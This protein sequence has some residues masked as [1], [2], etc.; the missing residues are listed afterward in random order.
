MET[1]VPLQT[2]QLL[3]RPQRSCRKT[4]PGQEHRPRLQSYSVQAFGG[5]AGLAI[6]LY[7]WGG[8]G[9]EKD[10]GL[11][12]TIPVEKGSLSSLASL[13]PFSILVWSAPLLFASILSLVQVLPQ[14]LL[15][16]LCGRAEVDSSPVEEAAPFP[17]NT[18][19]RSHLSHS[20]GRRYSDIRVAADKRQ[21]IIFCRYLILYSRISTLSFS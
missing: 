19:R 18:L 10:T 5:F 20:T 12:L 3:P 11:A 21:D 7:K 9:E 13:P 4:C 6:W 17:S 15:R 8:L 1:Q 14:D 16:E 2:L